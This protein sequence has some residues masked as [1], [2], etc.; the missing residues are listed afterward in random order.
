MRRWTEPILTFYNNE[1][2]FTSFSNINFDF[3]QLKTSFSI[4][5]SSMDISEHSIKIELTEDQTLQLDAQ[6]PLDC[7][8]RAILEDRNVASDIMHIKVTNV[9]KEGDLI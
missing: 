6:Y 5:M 3:R 4:P 9:L 7:Q 8:M 1:I 2:D